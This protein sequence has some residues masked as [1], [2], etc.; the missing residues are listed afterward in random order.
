M[1]VRQNSNLALAEDGFRLV[2]GVVLGVFAPRQRKNLHTLTATIGIRGT[3]VYIEA[4]R[5]R[6]YVCT[7]YGE[8]ALEPADNAG[9]RAT[10][11]PAQRHGEPRYIAARSI[12]PAPMRNHGEGE[13]ELLEGL[14][15]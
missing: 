4:E 14:R 6:T 13:I 12:A 9:A 3:A 15:R 7:C 1:L 8:T 2:T 5:T 11:R 10:V